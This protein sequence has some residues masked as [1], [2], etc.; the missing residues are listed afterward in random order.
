MTERDT[1]FPP[2]LGMIDDPDH[3]QAL[4]NAFVKGKP[5]VTEAE[6]T[7]LLIWADSIKTGN[8]LIETIIEGHMDVVGM[9]EGQPLFRENAEGLA[10]AEA[11]V[12]AAP[13]LQHDVNHMIEQGAGIPMALGPKKPQ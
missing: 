11:L 10:A 9:Q 2:P 5:T 3:I 7:A 6:L 12:L 1:S 4:I 13:E 8:A